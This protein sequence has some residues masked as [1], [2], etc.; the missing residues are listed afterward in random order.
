M[1]TSTQIS[2]TSAN[3]A[4]SW[5]GISYFTYA[6]YT[7]A[8]SVIFVTDDGKDDW[9]WKIE[10]Q[11]IQDYWSS[12][13]LISEARTYAAVDSF[14]MYSPDFLKYAQA[15]LKAKILKRP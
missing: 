11:W 13:E 15:F 5:F 2:F 4:I 6:K 14:L 7:Q 10:T 1:N 9:W 3:T 12:S 8:A